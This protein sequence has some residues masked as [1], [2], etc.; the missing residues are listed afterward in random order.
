MEMSE[1]ERQAALK[2]KEKDDSLMM[3]G[4]VLFSVVVA[5]AVFMLLPYFLAEQLER[6]QIPHVAI[7]IAEA[8][9][10]CGIFVHVSVG[11]FQDGGYPRESLCT[12]VRNIKCIQ[13]H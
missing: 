10:P 13:L 1:E 9:V 11:D 4:S 8:V 6:F 7:T 2:K 12:T 5:V 3:Y